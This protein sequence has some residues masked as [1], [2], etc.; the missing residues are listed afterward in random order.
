MGSLVN[1]C[2]VSDIVS[3]ASHSSSDNNN[4]NNNNSIVVI[5]TGEV[6]VA[7]IPE[8][9]VWTVLTDIEGIGYAVVP[10]DYLCSHSLLIRASPTGRPL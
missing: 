8:M 6:R 2:V 3:R 1:P 4:N 9:R 7:V 10:Y 5:L